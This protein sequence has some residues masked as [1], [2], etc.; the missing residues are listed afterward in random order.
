MGQAKA[1]H[2]WAA[3]GNRRVTTGCGGG[4]SGMER[5]P[6][7]REKV[8][9]RVG[10]AGACRRGAGV[11]GYGWS[12]EEGLSL[13]DSAKSNRMIRVHGTTTTRL[14]KSPLVDSM[15]AHTRAT[16]QSSIFFFYF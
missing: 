7:R 14:I 4:P 5:G 10:E 8:P 3:V 1:I 2:A 6:G 16:Q 15:V 12:D 13:G 11:H 9:T